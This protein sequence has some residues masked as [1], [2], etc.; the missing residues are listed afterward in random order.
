MS[1]LWGFAVDDRVTSHSENG[2]NL[3]IPELHNS[4]KAADLAYIHQVADFAP[5]NCNMC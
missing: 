2:K 5:E 1:H 3:G 4:V